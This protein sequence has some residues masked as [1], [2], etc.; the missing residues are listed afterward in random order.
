MFP[1]G[2][3]SGQPNA[4]IGQSLQE[5]RWGVRKKGFENPEMSND[6]ATS[7]EMLGEGFY[8][9]LT[10]YQSLPTAEPARIFQA[11]TAVAWKAW[12]M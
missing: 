8:V 12:N 7:R 9:S 5:S 3:N 11:L 4:S 2:E 6:V 1:A 10:L